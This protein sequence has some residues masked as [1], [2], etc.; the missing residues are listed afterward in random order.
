[1]AVHPEGHKVCAAVR[2]EFE[3]IAGVG[4]IANT[5]NAGTTILLFTAWGVV[6]GEEPARES[7]T[8]AVRHSDA[9]QAAVRATRT[10]VRWN[11][12]IWVTAVVFCGLRDAIWA[13]LLDIAAQTGL[14][15]PDL[16]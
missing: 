12:A 6:V 15:R 11:R 7:G 14:H 10:R 9:T 8:T 16:A 13:P 3:V 1:M 4:R 2:V 5:G